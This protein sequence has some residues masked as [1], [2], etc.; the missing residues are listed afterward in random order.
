MSTLLCSGI[1]ARLCIRGRH[2]LVQRKRQ[3]LRNHVRQGAAGREHMNREKA[4]LLLLL[5]VA[6]VAVLFH[7]MAEEAMAQGR[8]A[9]AARL[10]RVH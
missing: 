3:R 8:T 6:A 10:V 9:S 1:L 2:L 5:A 7:Q 4:L